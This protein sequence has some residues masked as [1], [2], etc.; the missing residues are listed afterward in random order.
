[1]QGHRVAVYT[2]GPAEIPRR[3]ALQR[4]HLHGRLSQALGVMDATAIAMCAINKL[5]ILVFT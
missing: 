1:M 5:P 3:R 2:T 4:N